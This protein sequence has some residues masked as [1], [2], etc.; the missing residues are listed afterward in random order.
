[1]NEN[2]VT[3]AGFGVD[4]GPRL[5]TGTLRNMRNTAKPNSKHKEAVMS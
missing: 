2:F 3:S 1:V 5:K 4:F